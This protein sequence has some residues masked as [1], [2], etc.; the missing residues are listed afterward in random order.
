MIDIKNL[1]AGILVFSSLVAGCSA[2]Y[3]KLEE[4]SVPAV[5]GSEVLH[6]LA[7][8]Y[9]EAYLNSFQPYAYFGD[10]E[11]DRHDLFLTNTPASFNALAQV[12][13]RVLKALNKI[14]VKYLDSSQ[15][16]MFYFKF[17][18]RLESNVGLR[19]CQSELWSVDHM[20]GPH[21]ILS[22]LADVQPVKT[23]QDR[24]DAIERWRLASA[25]YDQEIINLSHG[26]KRGYSAP[27]S[28]VERVIQQIDGLTQAHIDD[29][30]FLGLA[31]KA[32]N[33]E[34]EAAFKVVLSDQLIPSMK[35]YRDFLQAEYL[36]EARAELG[37][38]AIP[39][40]RECYMAQYRSYTTLQRTPEEV[41]ELGLSTVNA[42]R[43][44]VVRLG[45]D[46]FQVDTYSEAVARASEDETQKFSNSDE[47]HQFYE[48]LVDKSRD[49]TV[50]FFHE[51]PLI[52]MEVKAI[53]EHEWGSG[54]SAHYVPGTKERKA[55]FGYDPTTYK[56][57]SYASAEKVTIHEGYPGHH[58]QIALVQEQEKFHKIEDALSNSAFA[59]GWGRYAEHLAEEAGMYQYGSTKILRRAWP[60]RGMVADTAMHMLGWSDTE[61]AEFLRES[62]ASFA[63]GPS[64]LMDR[65]AVMPA[66][67]TSYDSGALEIFALRELMQ[68]ELEEGF[69]IKDFHEIVLRNGNVPMA[70]LNQQVREFIKEKK[71]DF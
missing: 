28:V 5:N 60:A 46:L 65:M 68:S 18:E 37:I 38:H 1:S 15:A 43:S 26:L 67:L 50:D 14:D 69:D 19:S 27:K 71:L 34:F 56:D 52:E 16:K 2:T 12:E 63:K 9:S 66:Q 39:N 40:G 31:K 42:N 47:M 54:R 45:R 58:M 53:P 62:G 10:I 20:F 70:V 22:F 33:P 59:E 6:D 32:E 8:E 3:N 21:I 35:R 30:P 41:F 25:Y 24:V 36:P 29:H 17:K 64:T 55:R 61:V 51:M 44:E 23:E 7:D 48:R 13:D 4:P 11:L 49:L 57:E